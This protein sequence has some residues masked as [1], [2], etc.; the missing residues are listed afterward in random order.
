MKL[1]LFRQA[2]LLCWN[3][4]QVLCLLSVW[5]QLEG[6]KISQGD[7]SKPAAQACRPAASQAHDLQ[8]APVE[9][10]SATR[11]VLTCPQKGWERSKKSLMRRLDSLQSST[12]LQQLP[13]P[14]HKGP[15]QPL[16]AQ[17]SNKGHQAMGQPR[18]FRRQPP[19]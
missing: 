3:S 13:Q 19:K 16:H 17:G 2:G 1:P 12:E 8:S 15:A 11:A 14:Q 7:G 18:A 4:S 10:G 9:P 5:Q 6:K